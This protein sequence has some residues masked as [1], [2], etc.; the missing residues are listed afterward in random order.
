MATYKRIYINFQHDGQQVQPLVP[1]HDEQQVQH[2]EQQV[3]HEALL[4]ELFM[5]HKVNIVINYKIV[6]QHERSFERPN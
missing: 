4:H 5:E 3:Q 2:D 1:Q 6:S